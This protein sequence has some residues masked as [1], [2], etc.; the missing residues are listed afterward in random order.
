MRLWLAVGLGA[1]LLAGA[2]GGIAYAMSRGGGDSAAAGVCEIQTLE[3]QGSG[4][5]AELPEDFEPNSYPRASGPHSPQTAIFNEYTEPV[6]EIN[7]VHNL[8]HG[9]VV[10]QYGTD[11]SEDTVQELR[12]WYRDDPRGLILAPFP[13]TPKAAEYADDIVLTA[14]VA[15]LE[16]ESDPTS[17]IVSQEGK[18][19][20]CSSFDEDAFDQFLDNYRGKGPERFELDQLQPGGG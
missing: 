1:L 18:L 9:G 7:I 14:W 3:E 13:D 8:E 2:I 10:V 19:A 11:V 16:D 6:P 4:H 15:E 5:V 20:V 17:E 12:S